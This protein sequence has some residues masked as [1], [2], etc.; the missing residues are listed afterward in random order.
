MNKYILLLIPIIIV[1]VGVF[2]IYKRDSI[3]TYNADIMCSYSS[4]ESFEDDEFDTKN[5]IYIYKDNDN[6][7]KTINQ[8]VMSANVD[9]GLL[10]SI[11]DMYKKIDGIDATLEKKGESIIFEVRYDFDLIDL[12]YVKE[13]IGSVLADDSIIMITDELPINIDD[14][15]KSINK[16]YKCEVK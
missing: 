10:E 1:I 5:F 11:V 7:K 3:P 12:D 13:E 8:S 14:Y 16:N 15:L 2:A 9:V 4:T 6:V